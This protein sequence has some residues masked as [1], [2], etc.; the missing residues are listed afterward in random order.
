[1][2]II[3]NRVW[4]MPNKWTFQIQPIRELIYKYVGDGKGWIDPF[5]GENSAMIYKFTLNN[6]EVS[7]NEYI[8]T[9]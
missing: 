5:A 7:N 9:P 4:A 3:Y 6:L 1:M 8:F 2:P